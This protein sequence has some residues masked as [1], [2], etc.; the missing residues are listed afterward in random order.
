[1]TAPLRTAA[2][3]AAEYAA[4]RSARL[5]FD[6]AAVSDYPTVRELA[7]LGGHAASL[8]VAYIQEFPDADLQLANRELGAILRD[9]LPLTD[10]RR[11]QHSHSELLGPVSAAVDRSFPGSL[12]VLRAGAGGSGH[13][14]FSGLLDDLIARLT[15]GDPGFPTR[16][17]ELAPAEYLAHRD[18]VVLSYPAARA[19]DPGV[20]CQLLG[21]TIPDLE[22]GDAQAEPEVSRTHLADAVGA[23]RL[24]FA[25]LDELLSAAASDAG[26]FGSR[27]AVVR[28]ALAD[29]GYGRTLPG[30][31]GEA[32]TRAADPAV[33]VAIP[34]PE[35]ERILAAARRLEP[36]P[37]LAEDCAAQ[38]A[39]LLELLGNGIPPAQV[40]GAPA[41]QQ[42]PSARAILATSAVFNHA[43]LGRLSRFVRLSGPVGADRLLLRQRKDELV[44][45]ALELLSFGSA[46]EGAPG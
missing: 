7:F 20:L 36:E 18:V 6:L 33:E 19:G 34:P 22:L 14:R 5:F 39:P 8:V 9:L 29:L 13:L 42:W 41:A 35:L 23:R 10:G 24:G 3:A 25:Y 43:G 45:K 27:M 40:I 11:S 4:H 46:F 30:L 1:M 15:D 16:L 26:T 37:F 31:L 2:A 38:I 12:V 17:R 44:T 21:H 32:W 28:R